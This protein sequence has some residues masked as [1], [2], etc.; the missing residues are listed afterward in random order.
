MPTMKEAVTVLGIILGC[1]IFVALGAYYGKKTSVGK[2]MQMAGVV[3]AIAIV[4]YVIYTAW[5]SLTGVLSMP[6]L[7]TTVTILLIIIGACIMACFG[8]YFG[9]K[10]EPFWVIVSAGVIALITI[11]LFVIFIVWRVIT[12]QP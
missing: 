11:I 10:I 4:L 12:N 8:G 1:C 3:T 2:V 7:K 5:G 9:K 6:D